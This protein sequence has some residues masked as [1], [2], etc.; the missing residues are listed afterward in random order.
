MRFDNS[1][2]ATGHDLVRR[3]ETL[4][5][6]LAEAHRREA[7]SAEILQLISSSPTDVQPVF[8]AIARSAAQLCDAEICNIFRFDGT[9]IQ[10]V[11]A[12]GSSLEVQEAMRRRFPLPPSRGFA[13]ARAI[14]SN[15]VEEIP[16]VLKDQD[17]AVHDIARMAAFRSTVAVPMRKDGL[18]IGA[19]AVVRLEPGEFD[20]RQIGLLKTFADQ[21]VIA[22]ENTRLFEE[23][24]ARTRELTESLE[25]QTA[26]SQ[27]LSVI[28]SSPT[29]VGPVLDAIVKTAAT[30]CSSQDAVILLKDASDLRIAAHNGPMTVDFARIPI[31]RDTVAGRSIVDREPVHVHDLAAESQSREFPLGQHIAVRLNQ[32]TVLGLPLLREGQAIGCLFLRRSELRPFT[33][34][35][36][37]LLQSFADQAVIAIENARL[38]E[39]VQAR[40]RELTEALE[41][42]TATSD[43]LGVIS[44]SPGELGPVFEAMLSNA[45]RICEASY[46]ALWTCEGKAFRNAAFHGAL[47]E[48]F[49]DQWRRTAIPPGSSLPLARVIETQKP[50]HIADMREDRS[51]LDGQPLAVTSVDIGG[52]R[53][54]LLVPMLK[55]QELV[56]AVAIYRKEVRPFSDKQVELVSNFAKQAV[57]AI[58]NTRLLNELR[59]SL[60]QQTATADVL[61]VISRSAFDLQTVLDTLVASAAHLCDAHMAAMLRQRGSKY[62]YA[63][64]FSVHTELDEYLKRVPFEPGRGT[65]TGRTLMERSVVH[66]HDAHADPELKTFEGVAKSGARTMLGVPLM[67]EGKPIGVMILMRRRVQPFSDKQIELVTTF[68]DQAVIAI[69]N[70][71]LF[72]AEQTS[73]R[74]LQES[75]EYQTAISEVLG[76]ISRSP[77]QLQPIVDAIVQTAK[78][79]CSAE[80]A[81]IWRFHEGKFDLLAYTMTDAGLTKYLT[82]NP[83]P[84]GRGSLSGR[85]ILARRA[86]HVADI[87]VH[88]ELGS[89]NQE[90][91]RASCRE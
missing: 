75:L 3:V 36:I 33:E 73:K 24:Q 54:L 9:S 6:E 65:V 88:P 76:V 79:L 11:A 70:T 77:S 10:F 14:L 91:G 81:I 17:Y 42:Q 49:T 55:E 28:S 71:R 47:S 5:R 57:I 67:R 40:T 82:E 29:D 56:G 84:A 32:R 2:D 1:T 19:I 34:K 46:G 58:D 68:A 16:D 74:E 43:V 25:Q 23:V 52:I 83:I 48:D 20:E 90:I 69:E 78:R 51:Y 66:V 39:Q 53:T 37:A 80:R 13:A 30:L 7:S 72:E 59:E 27:V 50:V 61:K 4:E 62:E 60:Q 86:L 89:Q 18:P 15:V 85:A 31:G 21:A 64:S 44:S 12:H 41:Q 45:V 35:Q 22:I 26:T 38:F 87:S 63:A 8:E